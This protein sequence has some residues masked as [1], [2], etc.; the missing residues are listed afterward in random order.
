MST[1]LRMSDTNNGTD[2]RGRT[3]GL[4]GGLVWWVIG[5][6][7]AGIAVFFALIVGFKT[8]LVPALACGL[9]PLGLVLAYVFGLRQGKPPGYDRDLFES[10][11]GSHGFGP[12]PET[13]L[14]HPER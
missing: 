14:V 8:A 2:S 7:A 11:V 5:G 9:A 3:W 12:E 10:W 13:D 6:L 1:E 4:D